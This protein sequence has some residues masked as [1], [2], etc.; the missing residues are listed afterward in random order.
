MTEAHSVSL[1]HAADETR[2]RYVCIREVRRMV[3][4]DRTRNLEQTPSLVNPDV[5]DEIRN[6]GAAVGAAFTGDERGTCAG[7]T[8]A[9]ARCAADRID[10]LRAV[11]AVRA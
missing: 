2:T 1:A 5:A 8:D 11:E 7:E 10:D 9:A 6:A 4:V 3:I